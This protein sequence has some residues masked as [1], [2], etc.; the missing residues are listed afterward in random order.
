QPIEVPT[1][2]LQDVVT[3]TFQPNLL[4]M[5]VEGH[6]VEI[7]SQ[8]AELSENQILSPNVIFETHLSRYTTDNDFA[9][10][11]RKLFDIG[12]TV[13]KAASSNEAGTTIISK[14]GYKG[15]EAFYSDF[16]H[17]VI[18]DNI[19]NDDAINV[20]CQTGGLRTILLEKI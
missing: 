10:V 4:R 17:R 8:L 6:E 15:S 18:F 7:L 1:L 2:T 20:I 11:L 14:L 5:D 12:Y 9:P 16:T 19:R 13:T 3:D